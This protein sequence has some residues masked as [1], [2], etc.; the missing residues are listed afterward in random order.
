MHLNNNRYLPVK[1]RENFVPCFSV[2]SMAKELEPCW[3]IVLLEPHT[4][5]R[6]S[7]RY[8]SSYT[9]R[10]SP[11]LASSHAN[12]P[13]N[14]HSVLQ[15]HCTHFWYKWYQ[16][17]ELVSHQCKGWVYSGALQGWRRRGQYTLPGDSKKS[18]IRGCCLKATLVCHLKVN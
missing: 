10:T 4:E 1:L 14:D 7:C 18:S 8:Y 3:T 17:T 11:G 2:V 16:Y 15:G 9:A 13:V 6:C 5:Y 12:C